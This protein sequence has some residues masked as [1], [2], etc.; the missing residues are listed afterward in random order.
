M[1]PIL[2]SLIKIGGI[3]ILGGQSV[4]FGLARDETRK[5]QSKAW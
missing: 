1:A 2:Q 5:K 3:Q 4:L